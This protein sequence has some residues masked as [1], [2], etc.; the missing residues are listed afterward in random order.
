VT[1]ISDLHSFLAQKPVRALVV[2]AML[3]PASALIASPPA[4]ALASV[5]VCETFG[6]FCV[7]APNLGLDDPV[8]ETTSGRDL[9]IISSGSG[10]I[11]QFA[12]SSSLCVAAA[13]NG[14]DVVQH[15]CNGGHG[16]IWHI[17]QGP[18]SNLIENNEFSGKFLSG[19]DN[20]TQF[21]I[22]SRGAAGWE[23]QYSIG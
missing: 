5:H 19:A 15:P 17:E 16:I 23:Q 10:V 11:L 20:G 14:S 3:V 9:N 6:A 22:R 8:V 12:A 7:G 18:T 13:N 4:S 1:K 21:M 2:V